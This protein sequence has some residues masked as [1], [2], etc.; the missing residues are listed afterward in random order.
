MYWEIK[1]F[2]ELSTEELYKILQLRSEVFVIEQ[3]CI[4][5]DC[6]KKDMEATH[7]FCIEEGKVIATLRILNKGVSYN[8]I[9]IGRVAV[10][11]EYRRKK[12]ARKSMEIA[13]EYVK[14]N[15]GNSPIRISAQCY[16]SDFYK[17]LGFIEVSDVYLEDNIPHIE[18]LYKM[19]N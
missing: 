15:Y 19:N 17:S 1:K 6:D 16:I 8:E 11:K 10:K 12:L 5:Q 7:L 18:M 14:E 4:Y 9:S 2:N 13:I 3:E